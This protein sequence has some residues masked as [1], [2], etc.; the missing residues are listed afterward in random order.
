M[1]DGREAQKQAA[2]KAAVKYVQNGM[3]LGLGTGSTA[4]YVIQEIGERW[5]AGSLTNIVGIPTS[6]KTA[7][8]VASYGIPLG[9][10][11]SHPEVDLAIDGADEV[12]PTLELVK[13]LGGA[14]LRE[15]QVESAAR[16]FVVV[17]DEGKLVP[18]LGTK[19]PL[20]VEVDRA[21]WER[22]AMWLEGFGCTPVL[23]GGDAPFLTESSNFIL[24]CSF[25]SGIADCTALGR[26]L[27]AHA[28]VLAHGLFLGMASEVVIAGAGGIRSLRRE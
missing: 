20:P 25:A 7:T 23:R 17:V 21:S 1:T 27:D 22:E 15:K 24:D 3:V 6:E 19:A 9:T 26:A 11:R 16:R 4:F 8:Q 12:D 2:A 28:G 18:R 10:L 14:L 13:G 5:R